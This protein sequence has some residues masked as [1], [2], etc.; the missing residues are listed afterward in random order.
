MVG[1]QGLK[2][3]SGDLAV[4]RNKDEVYGVVSPIMQYTRASIAD[5]Q[6]LIRI[7]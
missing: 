7:G 2:L 3:L 6:I 4:C 5:E 1:K